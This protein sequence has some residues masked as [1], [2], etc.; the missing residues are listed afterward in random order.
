MCTEC[1]KPF[2][3]TQGTALSRLRPPAETV[4]VV[5]TRMAHGCPRQ[6]LVVAC[7]SDERTVACWLARVGGQGQG[8]PEHR[9]EHPRALGQVQADERRVKTQGGLVWMADAA[10][11]RA[12]AVILYSVS[13]GSYPLNMGQNTRLAIRSRHL[14]KLRN[15]TAHHGMRLNKIIPKQPAN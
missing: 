5:G 10:V 13:K 11:K 14:G 15:K 3:A 1:H 9:V 4:R 12:C 2:S 6:A 8:V 7:G